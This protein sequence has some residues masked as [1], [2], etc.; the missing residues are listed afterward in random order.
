M[1]TKTGKHHF[2]CDFRTFLSDGTLAYEC[3]DW[4]FTTKDADAYMQKLI[5]EYGAKGIR[6][7]LTN[8]EQMD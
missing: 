5:R 1:V 3:I 4:A 7:E 2:K 6:A 8:I